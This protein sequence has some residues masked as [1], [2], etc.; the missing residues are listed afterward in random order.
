MTRD[1]LHQIARELAETAILRDAR[2]LPLMEHLSSESV[3]TVR[4]EMQR[5]AGQVAA[6]KAGKKPKAPTTINAPGSHF[7]VGNIISR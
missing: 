1:E 5:I 2:S 7:G 3:E 6:G 4:A